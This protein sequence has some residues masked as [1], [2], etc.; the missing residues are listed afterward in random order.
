MST[1]CSCRNDVRRRTWQPGSGP[2]GW[3]HA[4]SPR[5]HPAVTA[6]QAPA[7]TQW[8]GG[9]MG[10]CKH[11]PLPLSPGSGSPGRAAS[12]AH[13]RRKA[14]A[15]KG[16]AP[17]QRHTVS[18]DKTYINGKSTTSENN[19]EER[20]LHRVQVLLGEMRWLSKRRWAWESQKRKPHL[21]TPAHSL[22]HRA[23]CWGCPAHPQGCQVTAS[24]TRGSLT[25]RALLASLVN[26]RWPDPSPNPRNKSI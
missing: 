5:E 14:A 8:K 13:W 25:L 26:S 6:R 9:Q 22:P 19:K 10:S 7:H 18:L 11:F 2:H 20:R 17:S 21:P 16:P 15:P 23:C 12:R 4:D 1:C 3:A 24:G